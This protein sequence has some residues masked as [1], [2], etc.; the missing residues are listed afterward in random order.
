VFDIKEAVVAIY[1]ER[2]N[3]AAS[4]KD[5]DSIVQSLE[6]AIGCLI[7]FIFLA[8]YL[9][10]WEVDIV[11]GFST[12]S[13]MLLAFTFIFG[14]SVKN[15]FESMLF[16]FVEHPY[17]VGD[18]VLIKTELYR[19]KKIS[20]LYTEFIQIN[21]ERIFIPN[22]D[23]MASIISNWTRTKTK[24]EFVRIQMDVGVPP[25]VL[26]DIMNALVTHAAANSTE[27]DGAPFVQY[28]EVLEHRLKLVLQISWTYAFPPDD[29][30]RLVPARNAMVGI[31]QTKLKAHKVI[32]YTENWK[33]QKNEEGV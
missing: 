18:T 6:Y 27:F 22:T 10:I 1:R 12:F 11:K 29:W 28:R 2:A 14:N 32:Q 9:L 4:L 31:L 3:M 8:F 21:G 15:M 7:H 33:V 26:A 13:A 17:D 16:L 5:T 25:D 19:V 30:Q 23:L 24:T 20:L